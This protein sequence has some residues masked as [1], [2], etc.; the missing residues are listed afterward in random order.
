LVLAVFSWFFCSLAAAAPKQDVV[1]FGDIDGHW[2]QSDISRLSALELVRGYPDRTFKP[3]QMVSRLE[4][5]V[6]IVRSGGFTAEAEQMAANNK[7]KNDKSPAG[8][9]EIKQ[10]PKVPWGQSYVDLAVGK[11]FLVLNG[12][13]DYDDAGPADRLEVAELLARAMYLVPPSVGAEPALPEI[14]AP[15]GTASAKAFSDLDALTPAE[16][17]FVT[18]VA[19]ADVMSGYPDGTFRPQDSLTRAEMAV[20]LSRL[21]DRGWIKIPAERRLA[22]WISG[23]ENNK[24]R[25][26]TLTSL[27]GT[28]KLKVADNVQCYRAGEKRTL[29]GA[30]NFRC[31][32]ILD[33]RKQVSWINLLEKKDSIERTEKV[34]GSVKMVVLG[35]DNFIVLSDMSTED[36]MLPLAWD[37]VLTGKKAAKG[38]TSLKQGD[39][40]DVET[41]DGQVKEIS[42]LEVKTVSGKVDR[43][44]DRRLY[45]EGES[46]GSKP[47]WFNNYDYA[48]VTDKNGIQMGGVQA[49][50]KVTIT[51]LD[52]FPGEV[53]DEIPVEIK[54]NK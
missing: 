41:S 9:K 11:G 14:N 28:Q 1:I 34:R 52:P 19:N 45:F 13:E 46:S 50:D 12:P 23:I 15:A 43:I 38:F 27:T 7:K 17:V 36:L 29:E 16:R 39:F 10:T 25:E 21:V 40:V 51:Y 22:G 54:V 20:I 24:G 48:R 31:E 47:G 2:A 5:A 53:D 49:G 30:A 32:V 33:G 3:D 42:L 18:A 44:D 8:G 4:T 6:L 37:A 26:I 35:E